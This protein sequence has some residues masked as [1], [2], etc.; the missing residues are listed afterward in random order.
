MTTRV[1]FFSS[2]Y[3]AVFVLVMLLLAA[4]ALALFL[5][6]GAGYGIVGIGIAAF[7]D[8]NIYKLILRRLLLT[9]VTVDDEGVRVRLFG[10]EPRDMPW[11]EVRLAGL[12]TAPR[13]L[14]RRARHLFV[15]D[16]RLDQMLS[17]STAYARFDEMAAAVRAR[18]PSFFEIG[19]DADETL[20]HRLLRLALR[21]VSVDDGGIRFALVGDETLSLAW[22]EVRLAGVAEDAVRGG[23]RARRLFVCGD[24]DT[25][26]MVVPEK[27]ER[28]DEVVTAVRT[29]L[30]G[31]FR[32]LTLGARE[33]LKNRL[34]SLLDT[35]PVGGAAGTEAA[36]GPP[37]AAGGPGNA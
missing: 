10:D 21:D 37:P 12:A 9:S 18:A 13:R 27:Y 35:Q 25:R 5:V 6:A 23:S 14:G 19:V 15:V 30:G 17:F 28:F 1:T 32:E 33:P 36:A 24:L 31:A 26:W 22:G 11:A 3:P 2:P 4:A 8:W 20:R 29:R 34:Q 16:R 7:I